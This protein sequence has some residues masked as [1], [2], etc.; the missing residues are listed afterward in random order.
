MN[1]SRRMGA[2]LIAACVMT[3]AAC[4]SAEDT[5]TGGES[6]SSVAPPGSSSPP[7]TT[8]PVT[9]TTQPVTTPSPTTPPAPPT[10]EFDL[11]TVQAQVEA[12]YRE[13]VA[14]FRRAQQDPTNPELVEAALA[15]TSGSSLATTQT[16]LLQLAMDGLRSEPE[17]LREPTITIEVPPVPKPGSTTEFEIQTCEIDPWVLVET[18]TGPGGSDAVVDDNIYAYRNIVRLRADGARWLTAEVI[19]IGTW[20]G[21]TECGES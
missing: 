6:P 15:W 8:Q 19:E 7:A 4:G 17:P 16:M 12:D 5:P 2:A 13:A 10:T 20:V 18:G 3:V 9:P 1:M 14:T 11:A 21:V